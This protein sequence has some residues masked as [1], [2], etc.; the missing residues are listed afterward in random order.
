MHAET[1]SAVRL[2]PITQCELD[3]FKRLT[4]VIF[5]VKYQVIPICYEIHHPKHVADDDFLT[6][7]LS[8][9]SF[10]HQSLLFEDFTQG[11]M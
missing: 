4:T 9:E 10:Y 5:P 8:Q 3:E 1:G 2:G 7:M 6:E 11:G